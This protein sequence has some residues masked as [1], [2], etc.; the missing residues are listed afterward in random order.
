MNNRRTLHDYSLLMIFVAVLDAFTFVGTVVSGFF[1][2]TISKALDTVEPDMLGA[3]KIALVIVGVLMIVLALSDAFIG[4]KGLKV[5][6][7]PNADKGYIVAAKVF[8]VINIFA[9][10]SAAFALTDKNT[11]MVDGLLRLACAVADVIVY[12]CFI[13][14]AMA[15]R[16][17]AIEKV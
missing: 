7:E 2:G 9:A 15:V 17:D 11:F 4:L 1:D 8:L 12:I 6:R 3:V 13:K 14:A 10:V 16:Q 5:S